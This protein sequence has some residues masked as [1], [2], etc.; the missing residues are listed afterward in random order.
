MTT[1]K[2]PD[3]RRADREGSPV[4]PALRDKLVDYTDQ[5]NDR[6]QRLLLV[7]YDAT[8]A[9]ER[10]HNKSRAVGGHIL[11]EGR[12]N[13]R[14][15][16]PVFDLFGRPASARKVAFVLHHRRLPQPGRY[17]K[18]TCGHKDCLAGHHLTDGAT[19]R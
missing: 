14:D 5:Y 7:D 10:L 9:A 11:W 6:W 1:T 19:T 15:K 16:S 2:H 3:P 8:R 12:I 13:S 18:T 4:S 17:I